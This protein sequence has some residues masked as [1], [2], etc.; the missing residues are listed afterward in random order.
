M[1]D[2]GVIRSAGHGS[3]HILP[4][5]QRSIE[6]CVRMVDWFMQRA[7]AQKITIPFLT[8]AELWKKSG[9]YL[10]DNNRVFLNYFVCCIKD[11]LWI[12]KTQNF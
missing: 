12:T 8:P 2:T 6:K 9:K 4:M 10:N 3:F 1:L 5:G 7:G 11:A